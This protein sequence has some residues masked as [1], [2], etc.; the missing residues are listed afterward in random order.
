MKRNAGNR[1]AG[2]SEVRLL[3]RLLYNLA[4]RGPTGIYA[5]GETIEAAIRGEEEPDAM[6]RL[7]RREAADYVLRELE[8]LE[9]LASAAEYDLRVFNR[10]RDKALMHAICTKTGSPSV[11]CRGCAGYSTMISKAPTIHRI[12]CA[13]VFAAGTHASHSR[14]LSTETG[15]QS[16]RSK[17]SSSGEPTTGVTARIGSAM[18]SGTPS[19]TAPQNNAR[20]S[21]ASA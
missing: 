3:P 8:A 19:S 2:A 6:P 10:D 9:E 18:N 20:T 21:S 15:R 5:D 12:G 4:T 11:P 7:T 1:N 14:R 17:P 13:H 16:R